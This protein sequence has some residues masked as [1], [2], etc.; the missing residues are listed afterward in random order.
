MPAVD[1]NGKDVEVSLTDTDPAVLVFKTVNEYE[2][3]LQDGL[4][5]AR[6]AKH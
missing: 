3:K 4:D 1:S 2:R 6:E 5:L